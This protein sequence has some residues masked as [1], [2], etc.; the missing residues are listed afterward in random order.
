[1]TKGMVAYGGQGLYWGRGPCR[2]PTGDRPLSPQGWATGPCRLLEEGDKPP[3]FQGPRCEFEEKKLQL[4]SV[5]LWG[6][7]RGIFL[8]Y[9]KTDIYF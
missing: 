4:G 6:G 7:D 1:M 2:P 5:A 3:F 8:K 9:F